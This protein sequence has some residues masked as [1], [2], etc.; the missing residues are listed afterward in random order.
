MARYTIFV[1]EAAQKELKLGP[2]AAR[3]IVAQMD[4]G[5]MRDVAAETREA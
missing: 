4:A 5:R 3:E 2:A 1:A